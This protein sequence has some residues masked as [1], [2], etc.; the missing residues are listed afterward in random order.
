[1]AVNRMFVFQNG[2]TTGLTDWPWGPVDDLAAFDEVMRAGGFYCVYANKRGWT[3]EIW[4]SRRCESGYQFM[5][6]LDAG[7][8]CYEIFCHDLFDLVDCLRR[9]EPITNLP[10]GGGLSSW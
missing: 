6:S 3:L 7:S 10:E 2:K 9:L 5:I 8:A 4:E 1:M